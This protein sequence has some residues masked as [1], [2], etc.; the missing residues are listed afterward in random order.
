MEVMLTQPI[1]ILMGWISHGDP[2][3]CMVSTLINNCIIE[4]SAGVSAQG[5]FTLPVV[6]SG[7]ELQR[8]Q[9]ALDEA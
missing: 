6:S 2:S 5:W 1:Y 9:I 8:F 3:P 7:L 4:A